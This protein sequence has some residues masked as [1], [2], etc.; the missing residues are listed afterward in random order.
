MDFI[1]QFDIDVELGIRLFL[2]EIVPVKSEFCPFFMNCVDYWEIIGE[3][4]NAKIL[5][6]RISLR[7]II[8]LRTPKFAKT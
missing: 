2:A 7:I 3:I 6:A 4:D 8:Y 1:A 5:T